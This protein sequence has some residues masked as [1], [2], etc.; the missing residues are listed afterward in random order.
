MFTL[1]RTEVQIGTADEIS[2]FSMDRIQV[3][4]GIVTL[5]TNNF[6]NTHNIEILR[7][8]SCSLKIVLSKSIFFG[9]DK[10]KINIE[11]I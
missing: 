5:K 11:L 4:I 2:Q 1:Y 8:S 7:R 3:Q 9:I 6:C 10:L